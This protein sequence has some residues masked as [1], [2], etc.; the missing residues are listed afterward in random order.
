MI[1]VDRAP[2]WVCADAGAYPRTASLW[3]P[4]TGEVAEV[5]GLAPKH[6]MTITRMATALDSEYLTLRNGG[7]GLK[8]V[9]VGFS[10]VHGSGC[11]ALIMPVK[12]T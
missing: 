10:G 6:L 8:P 9:T 11:R 7:D 2:R 12:R 4:T 5:V 1:S 3:P